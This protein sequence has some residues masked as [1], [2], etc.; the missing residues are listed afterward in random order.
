M[1]RDAAHRL[2]KVLFTALLGILPF[3][4]ILGSLFVGRY[5]VSPMEVFQILGEIFSPGIFNAPREEAAVILQLRLPRAIAAAFIG[6]GL[7]ASGAAFQGVFRNPLVNSGLLGVSSGAGFGAALAILLFG[8]GAVIYPLAF[9]FGVLAVGLSY[10]VARI[11]KSV[12]TVMLILGGTIISSLFNALISL[13]KHM[14]DASDE[15]PA[16]VYWLMG[17][18]ASVEYKDFWA[19]LPITLGMVI[20]LFYSWRINVLSMGDKEARTLGVDV[21]RN[22]VYVILAATLATAGSV[23]LAGTIGW[24]GLVIP[25]IG[26]M[27]VGNDNRKLLPVSMSMG[28]AFLVLIDT[29]SRSLSASEIPLG[30]LTSLVGAPF[31]IFLLKKTKG[32]GWQE[33]R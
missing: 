28:A 2:K 19:L 13:L 18:I 11:Y 21:K 17:S 16:I 20:L 8:A 27:V 12:P 14:A 1:K 33:C 24:V 26:R 25:H 6:A 22:K 4:F 9:S 10:W 3:L 23:C 15:L 7:S 5:R 29:L 31:F 32:G 30:I